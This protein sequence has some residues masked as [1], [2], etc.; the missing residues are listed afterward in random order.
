ME[1]LTLRWSLALVSSFHLGGNAKLRLIRYGQAV[2]RDKQPVEDRG[3]S[4]IKM[5]LSFDAKLLFF[6]LDQLIIENVIYIFIIM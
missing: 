5:P 1:T 6:V 4:G 2:S 3:N